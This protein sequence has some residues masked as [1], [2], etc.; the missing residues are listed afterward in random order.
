ME[1][2]DN[3]VTRLIP[4]AMQGGLGTLLF[5]GALAFALSV[6][7][8]VAVPVNRGLIAR[9]R[10]HA[11]VHP[12][13]VHGGP[14]PRLVGA[15]PAAAVVFGGTVLAVEALRGDAPVAHGGAM[16]VPPGHGGR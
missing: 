14:D 10:G 12:T 4:G 13:G 1:S 6:A 9:G 2:V 7:V 8:V 5:W 16:P 11:A 15:V 3:G